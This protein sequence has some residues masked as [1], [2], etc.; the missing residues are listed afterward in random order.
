MVKEPYTLT[1]RSRKS[2]GSEPLKEDGGKQR[3]SA[4]EEERSRG[5]DA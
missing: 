4:A 2:S 3:R 1:Q 5:G